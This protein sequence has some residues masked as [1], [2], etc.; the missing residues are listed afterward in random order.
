MTIDKGIKI[1]RLGR[2]FSFPLK[3]F[4]FPLDFFLF[5]CYYTL[6]HREPIH[7]VSWSPDNLPLF[8]VYID[9]IKKK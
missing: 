2:L 8:G 4:R 6:E 3:I 1:R 5:V 9:G 7:F